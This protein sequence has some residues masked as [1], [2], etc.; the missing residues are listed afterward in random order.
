MRE[1]I[2]TGFISAA[3]VKYPMEKQLGRCGLFSFTVLGY[4]P[5][6]WRNQGRNLK[7]L[8]ISQPQPREER[9]ELTH[10][11]SYSV[12]PLYTHST[13]TPGQGMVLPTVG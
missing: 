2:G 9:N 12:L 13:E 4:S 6:L 3:M 5:S 11:F 1:R 7:H 8:L 10:A